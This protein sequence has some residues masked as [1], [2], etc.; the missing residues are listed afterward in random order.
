[1]GGW[2]GWLVGALRAVPPNLLRL[3]VGL[4][5][6]IAAGIGTLQIARWLVDN[7]AL[8]V[9][10]ALILPLPLVGIALAVMY[11]YPDDR[12]NPVLG[13][14]PL[15]RRAALLI[16]GIGTYLV[17]L[18]LMFLIRRFVRRRTCAEDEGED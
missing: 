5:E 12:T 3:A 4:G 10:L 14:D 7:R 9:L 16:V 17:G 18:L 1:M 6:G 8:R 11:F 15:E 13:G 2:F